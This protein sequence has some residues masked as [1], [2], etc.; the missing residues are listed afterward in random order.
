[1]GTELSAALHRVVSCA[2]AG[3]HAVRVRIV[4]E[5][6]MPGMADGDVQLERAGRRRECKWQQR[7]EKPA[8]MFPSNRND[9]TTCFRSVK[10]IIIRLVS[11]QQSTAAPPDAC[12]SVER[13]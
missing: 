6:V 13:E 2:V 5:K 10:G 8:V 4:L 11:R 9:L 1:M 12:R 7:A 3:I